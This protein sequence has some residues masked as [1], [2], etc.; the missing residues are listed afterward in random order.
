[1]LTLVGSMFLMTA[2]LFVVGLVASLLSGQ[3]RRFVSRALYLE[4]E[5]GNPLRW[6]RDGIGV[7]Y[8]KFHC[9]NDSSRRNMLELL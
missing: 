2:V 3:Q 7:A 5:T 8:K 6:N 9:T 4:I 1:M